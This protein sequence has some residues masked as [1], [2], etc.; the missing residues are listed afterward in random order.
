MMAPSYVQTAIDD[1]QADHERRLNEVRRRLAY[2]SWLIP[3]LATVL[4]WP[5]GRVGVRA[6]LRELAELGEVEERD[7]GEWHATPALKFPGRPD[8]P[9][10][11]HPRKAEEAD[12]SS[13]PEQIT[14]LLAERPWLTAR[15]L[16]DALGSNSASV[17]ASKMATQ[18]RLQR[19]Q[20]DDGVWEYAMP[21]AVSGDQE[22]VGV[23]VAPVAQP[24]Q[25]ASHTEQ[26]ALEREAHLAR[27]RELEAERKRA[28]QA[29]AERDQA[30]R[31]LTQARADLQDARDAETICRRR[32]EKAEAGVDRA[33]RQL[34]ALLEG[35]EED[36]PSDLDTVTSEVVEL[37]GHLRRRVAE[38]ERQ[39]E[40]EQVDGGEHL[41][42]HLEEIGR[43]R[44]RSAFLAQTLREVEQRRIQAVAREHAA[45]AGADVSARMAEQ[46]ADVMV[47]LLDCVLTVGGDVRDTTPTGLAMELQRRLSAASRSEAA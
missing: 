26:C 42:M 38:L 2:R 10:R 11:P 33:A 29:E 22:P 46:L 36:D 31:L 25:P 17:A 30:D 37:V 43:L 9:K 13:I 41:A 23:P 21:D 44:R 27:V 16:A 28:D 4:E 5:G 47:R 45:Q 39:V 40:A 35:R 24:E 20:N 12:M 18:G 8:R 3:Q 32:A 34:E 6:V 14:A 1:V 19:R 7:G 15:A